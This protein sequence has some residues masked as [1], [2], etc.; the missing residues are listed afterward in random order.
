MLVVFEIDDKVLTQGAVGMLIER[1]T[2]WVFCDG[3]KIFQGTDAT[4]EKLDEHFNPPAE[5][6]NKPAPTKRTTSKEK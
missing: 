2:L 6:K 4:M 3:W 5:V 1:E